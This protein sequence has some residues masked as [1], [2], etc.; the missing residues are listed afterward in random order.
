MKLLELFTLNHKG[1][2]YI[3]RGRKL[4]SLLLLSYFFAFK[5]IFRVVRH[6]MLLILIVTSRLTI[7]STSCN[8][9]GN[10]YEILKIFDS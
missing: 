7:Y 8:E 6:Q 2:I 5:L 10:V 9:T 4:P 3:T 1:Q